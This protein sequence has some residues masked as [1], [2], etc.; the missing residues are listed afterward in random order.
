MNR[1]QFITRSSAAFA[2]PMFSAVAAADAKKKTVWGIAELWQWLYEKQQT[3]GHDTADCLQAHLDHGIRHVIWA[4]GRS[5]L[6]PRAFAS[7]P[8]SPFARLGSA[9]SSS[10]WTPASATGA[11]RRR[12]AGPA[13]V[14][15]PAVATVTGGGASPS[16]VV[17]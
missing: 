13:S 3:S 6:A 9:P 16:S 5:T 17:F 1:R 12:L 4:L 15:T 10:H 2:A 14:T 8:R 11:G 7:Q